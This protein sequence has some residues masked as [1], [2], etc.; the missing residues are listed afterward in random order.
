MIVM[1]ADGHVH[2]EWSW[3]APEGA[4][5]RTCERAVELGLPAIAFTEH[6][7]WT[8]WTVRDG[9]LDPWP[10]LKALE[11]DGTL[12]P[13]PFDFEGYFECLER[14]RD[15]FPSLRILSGV[16]VGEPHWHRDE[17]A[18]LLGAG[19]FDR[20]LGSLHNLPFENGYS[21]PPNHFRQR[22]AAEVLR[23]Y[24]AEIPRVVEGSEAFGVL[25]HIDYAVRYWPDGAEPFDPYAFEDEFRHAL[26]TL[27]DSGRV[28]E[29][30]TRGQ[31]PVEVVRWW[32]E[33]GGSAVTFGSD[34]HLPPNLAGRFEEAVAM[35]ESVGFR[36]GRHPYDQ[37]IR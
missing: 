36:P 16:E 3:D 29:V 20:V 4:M 1:P 15:R 25:A 2:S 30:N 9:E 12:T 22:P 7:D 26:R 11:V 35:V 27:A 21:E 6:V 8:V 10:H 13:P 18:E 19:R 23:D 37:W 5:E 34:A 33:A 24:L 32:K 14:C 17:V 28:L 31:F